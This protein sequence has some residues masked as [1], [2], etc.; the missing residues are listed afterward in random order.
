MCSLENSTFLYKFVKSYEGVEK[1][2]THIVLRTVKEEA[3]L[4]P[5]RVPK[6]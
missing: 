1:T 4:I 3:A 5:E 6:K 2:E